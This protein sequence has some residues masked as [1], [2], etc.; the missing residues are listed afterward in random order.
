MARVVS[1]AILVC[2]LGTV[3]IEA[4]PP[5]TEGS[6][7]LPVRRVVLY[8]S[9]IGFF[10]HVGRVSG[11]E[12]LTIPFTS[13]QLDDVLKTLSVVDLDGGQV[14]SVGYTSDAPLSRRLGAFGLP[15]ENASTLN[16][17]LSAM[18]GAR[19]EVRRGAAGASGRL[20]DVQERSRSRDGGVETIDQISIV[21]EAGEV[22]TFD[23]GGGTVVRFADPGMNQRLNRYL[24]TVA[25]SREQHRRA[26]SIEAAG[27]GERR[28]YV[29]YVSEVPVWKTTYRIVLAD[30]A[31]DGARLHGW[32]IVDNTVG[33][34]WTDIELSLVA[35]APQSF[36]QPI[37]QPLYTRRP[38]VPMPGGLL[39]S[40][41]THAATLTGPARVMATVVD[42]RGSVLPGVS[43]RATDANGTIIG[44]AVTGADGRFSMP[45][46]AGRIRID[47]TLQG[48]NPLRA[49]IETGTDARLVMTPGA[50][51]ESVSVTAE[52]AQRRAA[53]QPPPAR[54]GG[55]VGGVVG[56]HP[57][58]PPPAAPYRSS[59]AIDSALTIRAS[60]R[61]LG[62]MF[63]YKL[64]R[65]ITVRQNQ[66]AMVPIV[67]A[68]VSVERVSL[69]NRSEAGAR[70]RRAL[71]LTNTSGLTLDGGSVAIMDGGAFGGEGLVETVKPNERRLIS[72][73]ADLGMQVE[74]TPEDTPAGRTR[75]QVSRGVITTETFQCQRLR[76]TAR[77]QDTSARQLIVE[78]PRPPGWLL[79]DSSPKPAETTTEAYRFELAVPAATTASLV[80]ST[81]KPVKS[82]MLIAQ[83]AGQEIDQF[84]LQSDLDATTRKALEPLVAARR[85]LTDLERR[86][87]ATDNEM[88]GI[89]TGQTRIRENMRA[90]K[91]SAEEKLLVER[92]VRQ[93]S[94][95]EDR[96][97]SLRATRASLERELDE[98]RRA[99]ERLAESITAEAGP[100][101][102]PCS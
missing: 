54:V 34:D 87:Q 18:R 52:T 71:W 45:A 21:T 58:A 90:L 23:L 40:P 80:V 5:R 47:A 79:S 91:G 32:A 9:G 53:Q 94:E 64:T 96:L 41:Q 2:L 75:I 49:E 15:L 20:L 51:T 99:F 48:F 37:S 25:S 88:A 56:G 67:S 39:L 101:G 36:V 97:A 70:P 68:P 14:S 60:G 69:W 102:T 84:F 72:Y 66:S 28:L 42:S 8:K 100:L 78:Q 17:F 27:T 19:V 86:Y 4:Q 74:A 55:V 26:L 44:T 61:D 1:A 38:Q 76:Y 29:S 10:E 82:S 65:P 24:E 22:H 62:E 11:T 98:K 59:A 13:P 89:E 85:E 33:A 31:K 63:E 73:A 83:T 3:M 92:Y 6:R 57:A 93:L 30:N 77:N 12:R 43:V 95:Q 35:G 81:Y 50:M 46:E 7:D 16:E